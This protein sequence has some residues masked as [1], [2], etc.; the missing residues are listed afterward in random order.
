MPRGGLSGKSKSSGEV[1]SSKC[2]V[3]IQN[4]GR[5]LLTIHHADVQLCLRRSQAVVAWLSRAFCG[6]DSCAASVELEFQPRKLHEKARGG[7][8]ENRH[9]STSKPSK[10]TVRLRS[11]SRSLAALIVSRISLFSTNTSSAFES[12]R[13]NSQSS[14]DM[15][16]ATGTC[17]APTPHTA[18]A[19]AANSDEFREM[20]A[21]R[22]PLT[23]ASSSVRRRL[24]SA[25]YSS[26]CGFSS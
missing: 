2:G 4:A 15:F 12:A 24:T 23:T 8:V 11:G 20:V 25:A 5:R 21:T 19:T 13:T 6:T 10:N 3:P 16:S 18:K 17:T 26:N 7:G 14:A 22:V 9:L 1:P